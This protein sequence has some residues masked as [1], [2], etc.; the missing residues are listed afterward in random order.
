VIRAL[1]QPILLF[2]IWWRRVK[3]N[4]LGLEVCSDR[5]VFSP[6]VGE[7]SLD[8]GAELSVHP[9]LKLPEPLTRFML[10][11]WHMPTSYENNRQ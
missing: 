5:Q 8:L 1:R 9:G 11:S 7:E 3:L 6:V 10:I 4:S 2:A